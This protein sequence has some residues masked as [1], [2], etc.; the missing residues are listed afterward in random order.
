MKIYLSDQLINPAYPPKCVYVKTGS[1]L[2]VEFYDLPLC[3]NGLRVI[4]VR[5]SV[6][7][8]DG[9]AVDAPCE[10]RGAR[11]FVQF[12]ASNFTNYGFVSKGFRVTLELKD[13][14]ANRGWEYV[15][16]TGDIDIGASTATA[17]P[18][19]PG[20]VF[21]TKGG[22]LFVR[23]HVIDGVQHYVKQEMVF[24]PDPLL[25]WGAKWTGDYILSQAG[26][27]ISVN[28]EDNQ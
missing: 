24:D 13:D 3:Y 15:A 21:V 11:W 2:P 23:S 10:K 8:A 19:N 6:T 5:V 22:E 4:G 16:A 20:N 28:Q 25:G 12:A 1:A 7:N 9:V 26:D 17:M 27:Y 18:G 14:E